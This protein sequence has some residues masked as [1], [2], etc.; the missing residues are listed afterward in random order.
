M[1][2][3]EVEDDA[4]LGG[5]DG[6]VTVALEEPGAEDATSVQTTAADGKVVF[7]GRV[8]KA[9]GYYAS[10]VASGG[11]VYVAS[12][13]GVVTVLEAGDELKVLAHNELPEAVL[14]TPAIVEETL[15]VRTTKQLFAF[16]D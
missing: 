11:K 12:D 8:G 10:P 7:Q 14:A 13:Y 5:A 1:Q 9:G 2:S 6:I 4:A 3:L 15:F 16:R